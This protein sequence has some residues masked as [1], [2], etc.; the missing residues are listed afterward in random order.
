[1]R[2]LNQTAIRL[3]QHDER[4][5]GV[6]TLRR[7]RWSNIMQVLAGPLWPIISF[8]F[9]VFLALKA[10]E[11]LQPDNQMMAVVLGAIFAFV[12]PLMFGELLTNALFKPGA[13][14][15]LA[16]RASQATLY[17][18]ALMRMGFALTGVLAWCGIEQ[19]VRG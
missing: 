12:G 16:Q 9:S 2:A 4:Q 10:A 8:L 1:M 7:P 15:E 11:L 19:V 13:V 5:K 17:F 14:P 3:W 6:A 18:S